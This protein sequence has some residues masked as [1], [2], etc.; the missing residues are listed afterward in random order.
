MKK[1]FFFLFL[2][3]SFVPLVFA[4]SIKNL[5]VINGTLSRKFES[6]KNVYS[7]ILDESEDSLKI[8][9]E[10]NDPE[11]KVVFHDNEYI[12]NG[13]NKMSLE[14]ENTD[15]TKE[16]YTFYLEKEETTPVFNETILSNNVYEQKEIPF[17]SW[18]VGAV[19][20]IL[21]ALSFKVVVLGFKKNKKCLK[22]KF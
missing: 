16:I 12:E 15:G 3:F 17:L 9:Y 22:K 13:K 5:E 14:V 19:C 10:L 11:A 2:F 18:Y 8:T 20:F 4:D 1:I 6:T 7:V 21:I